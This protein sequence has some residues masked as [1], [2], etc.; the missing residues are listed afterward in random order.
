MSQEL[1]ALQALQASVDKL[2]SEVKKTAEEALKEAKNA[3][4]ISAELKNKI[5]TDATQLNADRQRLNDME[6][7]LGEAE[8]AFAAVPNRVNTKAASVGSVFAEDEKWKEFQ[9]GAANSSRMDSCRI[10]V[11]AAVT[12]LDSGGQA[13]TG[14]ENLGFVGALQSRLTIR[15]LLAWVPVS[16][17]SVEYTR[18]TGFTN[19]ANTIEENPTG[20]KAESELTFENAV[21]PIVTIA[22]WIRA[23]KQVLSDSKMLAAYINFRMG[24]GLKQKEEA[25]LLYGSGVGVN[26]NGL[27]TQAVAYDNQGITVT[28]ETA[29]DRMRI[30][31]L[32]VE[33]ADLAP[34]G[35][36]L[37]PTDWAAIELLKDSQNRYLFANP[38]GLT[39]PTLWAL[40]VAT[41]KA[42]TKG[43]FLTGAFRQGALGLDREEM[44]IE[45]FNQDR[46]NVVKN[47]VTVLVEERIGLQ[48]FRPEAFVKG[49]LKAT[50]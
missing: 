7:Q 39:V 34:E 44:S 25:Q 24:Y 48:V 36:V 8:K 45:V 3:G 27:A 15:D 21:A 30:A 17:G 18:E 22:H 37:H 2:T 13:W 6:V 29:L 1:A 41:T 9:A 10:D 23:T 49:A 16:S 28:S 20:I 43:N 32:Q 4:Q 38:F 35:H 19:N 50:P 47:M 14:S 33:L 12:S 5:D 46:D 40:P 42:Q 26:I 11:Q 31:M